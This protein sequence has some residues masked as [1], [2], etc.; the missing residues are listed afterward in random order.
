MSFLLYEK[1]ATFQSPLFLYFF[2]SNIHSVE[3]FAG[4]GS[5]FAIIH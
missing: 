3:Q 2:N 4:I 1:E 5:E